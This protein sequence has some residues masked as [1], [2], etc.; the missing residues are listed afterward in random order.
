MLAEYQHGQLRRF[1][2]YDVLRLSLS[3]FKYSPLSHGLN[4]CTSLSIWYGRMNGLINQSINPSVSSPLIRA[5]RTK[6]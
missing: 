2:L 4:Q 1:S 5:S 6:N 3:G